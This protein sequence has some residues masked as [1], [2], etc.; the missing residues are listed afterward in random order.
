VFRHVAGID[1]EIG[2]A[3]HFAFLA[4]PV[5]IQNSATGEHRASPAVLGKETDAGEMFEQRLLRRYGPE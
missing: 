4:H 1:V 5:M 2:Q 3:E